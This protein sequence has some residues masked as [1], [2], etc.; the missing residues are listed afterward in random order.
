MGKDK[1]T[2]PVY[3][4]EFIPVERRLNDRRKPGEAPPAGADRRNLGRRKTDVLPA[5]PA[6]VRTVKRK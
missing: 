1:D 2:P 3:D 4:V 5:D 6:R